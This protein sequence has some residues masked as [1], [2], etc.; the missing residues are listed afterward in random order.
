VTAPFP[1]RAASELNP[2]RDEDPGHD[3]ALLDALDQDDRELLWKPFTQMRAYEQASPMVMER[4]EGNWLQDIR[5][6]AYLDGVSS[7]WVNLHGHRRPEIDEAISRQ[8][9]RLAHSTMLGPTNVKAIELA[10]EL[11][12]IAPSS[13][14][15]RVFYSDSGSTAVEI[16]LKMA[17]QYWQQCGRPG[18]DRR[19]KF[20]CLADAYH[21]DTIGSVS[22]GGME[23]FHGI[24]QPLLFHTE[25][26]VGPYCYRC[27]VGKELGSCG[28]ACLRS[29]EEVF[30]RCGDEVAALVVEPLVQGAAGMHVYPAEVLQGMVDIARR[31]G[32]LVI[33]DEVATGFGRS[34]RMFACQVAGVEPDL[35][36]VAKGLSGGYLPL[37]ATLATEEI[38]G[39]FKG[40]HTEYRTFFHGHSYTGNALACAAAVANL[41]LFRDGGVLDWVSYKVAHLAD[42]LQSF[43][44]LAHV[45]D[46]R[47]LGLM[48]GIEVVRD[49]RTR[50]AFDPELQVGNA[51]CAAARERGVLI[52]PLGDTVILM[53]PLNT[54][55]DE[56]DLL[57]GVTWE[58]IDEVTRAQVGAP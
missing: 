13:K 37:A 16:A 28:F 4:G 51:V 45:G 8:L 34:G 7:L 6:N 43:D 40:E 26:V 48:V 22:V 32:A 47:R 23:L 46:V 49:R 11:V 20:V 2:F 5:G 25:R 58:C 9:G 10:R 53:P 44:G 38:Y 42:R 50:E 54:S 12:A 18:A 57:C 19:T 24:Y 1:Y 21:G 33:A 27:P 41:R 14:L 3:P 36:A 35:L 29:V 55:S 39:A 31:H 30:E 52:R 17:F 15:R 56:L